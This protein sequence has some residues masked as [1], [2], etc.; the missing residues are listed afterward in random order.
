MDAHMN[1][2]VRKEKESYPYEPIARFLRVSLIEATHPFFN[3]VWHGRHILDH[4]SP[5][6]SVEARNRISM[7][8]GY[9]PEDLNDPLKVREHLRF[10][11]VIITMTGISNISAESVQISQRYYHHDVLIGYD[12][13]PLLY[14]QEGSE[15]L[16]V[17]MKLVNDVI[18]QSWSGAELLTAHELMLPSLREHDLRKHAGG[19]K[20]PLNKSAGMFSSISTDG[21]R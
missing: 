13:A 20:L 4:N 15:M 9:W 1:V 17:D 8:N 5:L 16:K 2:M 11:S 6:V 21:T 10:S 7:N 3:R 18:E 14:K 12:F 19:N